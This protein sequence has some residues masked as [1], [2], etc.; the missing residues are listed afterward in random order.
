[1]QPL[2]L[3]KLRPGRAGVLLAAALTLA[4]C[5]PKTAQGL[6]TSQLD[7]Q[8]ANAIGDPSTCVLLADARTGQVVY[9]YGDDFNC[10]R[11]LPACDRPGSLTATQALGLATHPGGRAASCYTTP[12][13]TSMVGWAEGRVQGAKRDLIYSAVMEGPRAL[14]GNWMQ[15]R[16]AGAFQSAGL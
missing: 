8:I 3:S 11:A 12:D 9:R 6:Q 5:A 15:S 7:N 16:L 13:H 4:A 2:M 10:V 1:M 14:P